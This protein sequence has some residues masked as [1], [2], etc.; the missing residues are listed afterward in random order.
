MPFFP[1]GDLAH[2]LDNGFAFTYKIARSA[3]ATIVVALQHLHVHGIVHE[4]VRPENVFIDAGG[5]C[6]LSLSKSSLWLLNTS[7]PIPKLVLDYTSPEVLRGERPTPA[8]DWW[9]FGAM[10]AHMVQGHPPFEAPNMKLLKRQIFSSEPTLDYSVPTALR[11]LLASLLAKDPA[12]RLSSAAKVIRH[13]FFAKVDWDAVRS[14]AYES[15]FQP[16]QEGYDMLP[17]RNADGELDLEAP[18]E[19]LEQ[20]KQEVFARWDWNPKRKQQKLQHE[21]HAGGARTIEDDH[22]LLANAGQLA[23]DGCPLESTVD[24]VG[25]VIFALEELPVGKSFQTL[26]GNKLTRTDDNTCVLYVPRKK[27]TRFEIFFSPSHAGHAS[28]APLPTSSSAAVLATPTSSSSS[29]SSPTSSSSTPSSPTSSSNLN[30]AS[31]TIPSL[32]SSSES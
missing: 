8:S 7:F 5:A 17:A 1:G 15:L 32:P 29:S 12:M 4:D 27:D 23:T 19:R 9:S 26:Q 25:R 14:H 31:T 22:A 13:P 3:I 11:A 2:Y 21:G 16:T 6:H 24:G 18:P 10:L 28:P 20:A 30:S